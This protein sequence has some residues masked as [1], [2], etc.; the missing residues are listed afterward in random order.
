M[1]LLKKEGGMVTLGKLKP[2]H[3]ANKV[4]SQV[5][6]SWKYTLPACFD[7][8]LLKELWRTQ[9]HHLSKL[10]T[11]IE[12]HPGFHREWQPPAIIPID[13]DVTFVSSSE[14]VSPLCLFLK[15]IISIFS[16]CLCAALP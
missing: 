13:K 9:M 5:E 12:N 1:G 14:V 4:S 3:K 8:S 10:L 11:E 6:A 2:K 15:K 7:K 16:H